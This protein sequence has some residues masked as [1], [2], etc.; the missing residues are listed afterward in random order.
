MTSSAHNSNC[1]CEAR[2]ASIAHT[3]YYTQQ[4]FFT[5][6]LDGSKHPPS[7]SN[8]LWRSAATSGGGGGGVAYTLS[9]GMM[10]T[11]TRL[12]RG[13]AFISKLRF[14][15]HNRELQNPTNNKLEVRLIGGFLPCVPFAEKEIWSIYH[16]YPK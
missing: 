13:N 1:K 7:D 12:L 16:T 5:S 3:L 6:P 11:G 9:S 4:C 2:Y 14:I 8:P 15:V 10:N